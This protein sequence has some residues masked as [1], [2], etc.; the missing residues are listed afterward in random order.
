MRICDLPDTY[1]YCPCLL[2]LWPLGFGYTY[3]RTC[4]ANP[5]AHV[6]TTRTY[7]PITVTDPSVLIVF[8]VD[9]TTHWKVVV[10]LIENTVNEFSVGVNCLFS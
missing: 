3:V 2:S 1:M 7:L 6:T 10:P 9:R 8:G 4:Q 5:S